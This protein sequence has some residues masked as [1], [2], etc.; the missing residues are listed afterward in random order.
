MDMKLEVLV[1]PVT[2]VDRAKRFYQ[3][4]GFRV[5][6]EYA[7]GDY[8]IMQLTPPGSPTSII[9]GKGITSAPRGPIDRMVLAVQ[10]IVAARKEL[11]SH[12]VEVSEVFHDVGGLF[13][14]A[15]TDRGRG[16]RLP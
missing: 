7:N 15:G 16:G 13:H 14:H 5:D 3:S 4:L 11:L 6:I 9:I 2:D 8:R 10:D 12:G 1:V